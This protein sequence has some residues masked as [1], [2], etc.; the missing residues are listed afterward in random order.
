M[1]RRYVLCT[2]FL[3]AAAV[4]M[5]SAGA[6]AGA[7][8]PVTLRAQPSSGPQVTL[9]D[10]FDGTG[11]AGFVVIGYGA[12]VGQSAVLDAGVVQRLARQHGLDWNNPGGLG[13]ILVRGVE[14]AL[15][16]D[17]RT[18]EALTYTRSLMAGDIVEPGDLGYAK[19]AAFAVPPDAP[20]DGDAV[21]GMTARRPLRAGAPVAQRDVSAAQVIKRDDVV[22]VTY[23]ADGISLV[24]QGKAMA[25]A[26]VGE[27]LAVMNTGSKKLIQ[28][29]AVGP[30][31]AVVGPDAERLRAAVD[32]PSQFAALR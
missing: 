21:I 6:P 32:T 28:A 16:S 8:Q 13:R 23:D 17:A 25:A 18:V 9:G 24:L 2:V 14:L 10:L 7:G 20:R 5:L 29:I 4:A 15:S 22:E 19:V 11:A 3:A 31:R 26:V 30:D 12:P 1:I 27:P